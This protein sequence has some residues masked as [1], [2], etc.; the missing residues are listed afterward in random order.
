MKRI[1]PNSGTR[2]AREKLGLTQMELATYLDIG[3]ST[4]AMAET[5]KGSLPTKAL[6]KLSGLV[7][8]VEQLAN[9]KLQTTQQ[10]PLKKLDVVFTKQLQAKKKELQ[11][12]LLVHQ[13]KLGKLTL[14]YA[15]AIKG[16][17]LATA[18]QDNPLLTIREKDRAW[19]QVLHTNALERLKKAHPMLQAQLQ[20]KIA[21]LQ[22][23]IVDLDLG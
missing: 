14:Q 7:L 21:G 3:L 11:Y 2:I 8:S 17:T 23:E 9:K 12:Q 4:L 20:S 13:K 1:A 16:L 15:Q 18:M 19:L 22:A 5:N 10:V 6:L